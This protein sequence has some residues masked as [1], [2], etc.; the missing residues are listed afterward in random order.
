MQIFQITYFKEFCI[1]PVSN[2]VNKI[3]ELYP[4][5]PIIGFPRNSKNNYIDYGLNIDLNLYIVDQ[6]IDPKWAVKILSLKR[7]ENYVFREI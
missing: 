2:I 7:I 5:I 1:K 3:R 4:E 6:N